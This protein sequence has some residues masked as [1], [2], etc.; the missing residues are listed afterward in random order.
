MGRLHQ[1]G[2]DRFDH[3][4]REDEAGAEHRAQHFGDAPP[5]HV[6]EHQPPDHAER[7][8]VH[9]QAG[10]VPGG[11]DQGERH[12]RQPRDADQR[13][14][15]HATA[16]RRDLGDHLDADQLREGV[17]SD[18]GQ[19]QGDLVV[20]GEVPAG[21]SVVGRRREGLA[22]G[23]H[24]KVGAEPRQPGDDSEDDGVGARQT[25]SESAAHAAPDSLPRDSGLRRPRSS[26]MAMIERIRRLRLRSARQTTKPAMP[27]PPPSARCS[28][29]A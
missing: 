17:A 16:R 24:R 1:P 21:D 29:G 9:E 26:V 10:D 3:S 25:S 2:A 22:E 12:Q 20:E 23:V 4:G 11:R 7:Q 27:C 13:Q 14:D 5:L 19:D 15:S 8:P 18:L 28:S 6:A